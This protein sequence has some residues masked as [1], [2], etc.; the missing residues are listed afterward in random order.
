MA[1]HLECYMIKDSHRNSRSFRGGFE[2][3][4]CR[5]DHVTVALRTAE[6]NQRHRLLDELRDS[7]RRCGVSI[8]G[9]SITHVGCRGVC[10]Q[11]TG[12]EAHHANNNW[13]ITP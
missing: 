2:R 11:A 8:L 12:R 6:Y 3:T 4:I 13:R 10:I 7:C 9:T 5:V 1:N